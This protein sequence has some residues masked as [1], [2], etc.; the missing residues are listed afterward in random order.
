[1]DDAVFEDPRWDTFGLLKEA[2]LAVA[3]AIEL[4]LKEFASMR[5][6]LQDLL[7]RLV[8]SPDHQLRPSELSQALA[9]TPS[10][11]TRLIDEGEELGLV[12]REPDDADKRASLITLTPTG[13]EA[14]RRWGLVALESSTLHAR[15]PLGESDLFRLEMMLRVLRDTAQRYC[16]AHADA[17]R[18]T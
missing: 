16:A 2:Y 13:Y 10:S 9:T 8:R 17:N 6:E 12:T 5:T 15:S 18:G 7:L 1:M 3:A 11:I 14:I 4:D